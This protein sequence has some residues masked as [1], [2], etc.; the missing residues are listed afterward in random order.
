[1]NENVNFFWK[2]DYIESILDS[3]QSFGLNR[4]ITIVKEFLQKQARQY[5]LNIHTIKAKKVKT[6][7]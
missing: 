5:K 4:L 3:L 1:M 7:I 6:R 2:R